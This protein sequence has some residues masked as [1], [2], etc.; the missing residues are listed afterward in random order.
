M[1]K[2]DPEGY[3]RSYYEGFLEDTGSDKT[4]AAVL[5][6]ALVLLE[7]EAE[8]VESAESAIKANEKKKKKK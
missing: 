1:P 8:R 2:R 3:V 4:A 5:T 7:I 6:L